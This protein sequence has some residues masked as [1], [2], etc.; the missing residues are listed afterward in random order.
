ME[1][2]AN[3]AVT[4]WWLSGLGSLLFLHFSAAGTQSPLSV[5]EEKGGFKQA[6]RRTNDASAKSLFR[7]RYVVWWHLQNPQ[8]VFCF[9]KF[10]P[11]MRASLLHYCI[12]FHKADKTQMFSPINCHTDTSSRQPSRSPCARSCPCSLPCWEVRG[13]AEELWDGRSGLPSAGHGF[14]GGYSYGREGQARD[15]SECVWCV[16]VCQRWRLWVRVRVCSAFNYSLLSLI[17]LFSRNLK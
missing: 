9:F 13:G 5:K 17:M 12:I 2:M 4:I 8:L 15:S 11:W 1:L 3:Q 10:S 16:C 7:R 14:T 6:R